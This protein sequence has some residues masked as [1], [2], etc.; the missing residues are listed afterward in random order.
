MIPLSFSNLMK[1]LKR[2]FFRL[3]NRMYFMAGPLAV[4][5]HLLYLLTPYAIAI[6]P[7]IVAFFSGERSTN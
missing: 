2:T 1:D 5:S 3:P 4:A 6:I 7:T